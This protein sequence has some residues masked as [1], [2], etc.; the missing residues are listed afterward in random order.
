MPV[1][2]RTSC[3]AHGAES[4]DATLAASLVI[5]T[6]RCCLLCCACVRVVMPGKLLFVFMGT[7]NVSRWFHLV[8]PSQDA[9][10]EISTE[11]YVPF[12]DV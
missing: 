10:P 8:E 7:P 9:I 6:C 2:I 11:V 3:E 12:L 4:L 5:I 1:R